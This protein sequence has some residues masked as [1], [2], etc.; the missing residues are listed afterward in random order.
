M[1]DETA[2]IQNS[3]I[4]MRRPITCA[5]SCIPTGLP[6]NKPA[7]SLVTQSHAK[8]HRPPTAPVMT[9]AA[10]H[11]QRMVIHVTMSGAAS[12]PIAPPLLKI[13]LASGRSLGL[14][15]ELVTL[16]E[17]G[18]LKASLAP[19]KKRNPV[20][21][22]TVVARPVSMPTSDHAPLAAGKTMRGP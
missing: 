15:R 22:L 19:S 18:Q 8:T 20:S 16:S 7:D 12:A 2:R 4:A 6:F 14:R 1:S 13:P 11:D 9:N 21:M 3:L 5:I 10:C 17:H